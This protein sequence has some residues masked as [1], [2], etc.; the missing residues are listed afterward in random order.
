MPASDTVNTNDARMANAGAMVVTPCMRMPGRPTAPVRS[1]VLKPATCSWVSTFPTG[2]PTLTSSSTGLPLRI[3]AHRREV[4][5]V[6]RAGL[7]DHLQ[8]R[9]GVQVVEVDRLPDPALHQHV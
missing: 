3:H 4:H 8:Q 1:S 2:A 6:A 5:R 7:D 9:A